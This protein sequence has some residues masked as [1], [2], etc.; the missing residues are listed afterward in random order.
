MKVSVALVVQTNLYLKSRQ[1]ARD[2]L[3]AFTL[4]FSGEEVCRVAMVPALR[5][6]R[7]L[8]VGMGSARR[9]L[10]QAASSRKSG[11]DVDDVEVR[12]ACTLLWGLG[13]PD[14]LFACNR[15]VK[16]AFGRRLHHPFGDPFRLDVVVCTREKCRAL[17]RKVAHCV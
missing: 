10:S 1:E 4:H 6:S 15:T 7:V 5:A 11:D 8:W 9:A 17:R 3:H 14:R 16:S 12:I 13:G 2:H